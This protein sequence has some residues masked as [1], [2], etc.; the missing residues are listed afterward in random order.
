MTPRHCGPVCW[1]AFKACA[2]LE[3]LSRG[4]YA[5]TDCQA[6][7]SPEPSLRFA[8]PFLTDAT[9]APA[10]SRPPPAVGKAH[11]PTAFSWLRRPV[12]GRRERGRG[13]DTGLAEA[14]PRRAAAGNHP[15]SNA[16]YYTLLVE[17]S[18]AGAQSRPAV[19]TAIADPHG[20]NLGTAVAR[21]GKNLVRPWH[22]GA[23]GKL[24][25]L[26]AERRRTVAARGESSGCP[27][28][29]KR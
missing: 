18:A 7:N 12:R 6:A 19:G 21:K 17:N 27:P 26:A 20:G 5:A 15:V 11:G 28:R 29:R 22:G 2:S 10:V 13:A 16:A 24:L 14:R 23:P 1:G 25:C 4:S 9:A 8:W 3:P